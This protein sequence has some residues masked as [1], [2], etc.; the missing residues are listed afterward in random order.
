MWRLLTLLKRSMLCRSGSH[1][2]Q[3]SR[4]SQRSSETSNPFHSQLLPQL[5]LFYLL[6]TLK[7][8]PV[9]SVIAA[10]VM[11]LSATFVDTLNTVTSYLL[12]W[13][14]ARCVK[15]GDTL[16]K[17]CKSNPAGSHTQTM[18]SVYPRRYCL[19]INCLLLRSLSMVLGLGL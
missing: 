6:V 8:S 4:C 17:V 9:S 12:R 10:V 3:F 5:H 15:R 13:L 11:E 19:F 1:K 14:F 16:A 18:A 2:H 7:N